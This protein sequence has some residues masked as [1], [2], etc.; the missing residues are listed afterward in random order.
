[1]YVVADGTVWLKLK[2]KEL[3]INL[4]GSMSAAHHLHELRSFR[5]SKYDKTFSIYRMSLIIFGIEE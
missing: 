3:N 5:N 4:R 2:K 1:M